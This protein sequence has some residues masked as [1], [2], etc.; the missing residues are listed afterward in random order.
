L[1]TYASNAW[2]HNGALL[3]CDCPCWRMS[4]KPTPSGKPCVSAP[5]KRTSPTRMP[6]V[7]HAVQAITPDVDE[8]DESR[9]EQFIALT[10]ASCVDSNCDKLLQDSCLPDMCPLLHSVV[11]KAWNTP[12]IALDEAS[13]CQRMPRSLPKKH[14]RSC[15]HVANSPIPLVLACSTL[16]CYPPAAAR[17]ACPSQLEAV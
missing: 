12:P 16:L 6:I 13:H 10:A 7:I 2:R 15:T 17:P 11:A 8:L 3:T 1:C 9:M 14:A 4:K 5:N